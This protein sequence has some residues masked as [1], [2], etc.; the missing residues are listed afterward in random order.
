[1]ADWSSGM[2]YAAL[3][4]LQDMSWV[5]SNKPA[6]QHITVWRKTADGGSTI[7]ARRLKTQRGCL[8]T[9]L[10]FLLELGRFEVMRYRCSKQKL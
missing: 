5:S 2:V 9:P 7:F 1:M 4:A 8:G 3:L 10:N 6:T